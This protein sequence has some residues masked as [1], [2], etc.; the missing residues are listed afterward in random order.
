MARV[1]IGSRTEVDPDGIRHTVQA[2]TRDVDWIATADKNLVE[3]EDQMRPVI[4][5]TVSGT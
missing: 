2:A 4:T 5:P 3:P 1:R